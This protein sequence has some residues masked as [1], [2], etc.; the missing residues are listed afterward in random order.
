VS[1]NPSLGSWSLPCQS[2]YWSQRNR[3]HWARRWSPEEIAAGRA[4]D[5]QRTEDFA[6]G[7]VPSVD[8]VPIGR[9]QPV[10]PWALL[11][12]LLRRA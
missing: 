6:S 7:T 12:R 5:L 9:H 1:L 2:H 10:R 11:R 8:K 3:V 4:R